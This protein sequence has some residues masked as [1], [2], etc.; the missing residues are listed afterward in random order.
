MNEVETVWVALGIVVLGATLLDVFLTALNYDE[1]GFVSG[2]VAALQWRVLRSVTR[3]M[4]RRA[5]P[6]A[7]RQ[8]T[9]LQII[10]VIAVWLFGV[11]LGFGLIYYGQ[12]TPTSFSVSG[13][14]AG[15]SFFDAMYFSAAQLS[16]VGG[17]SLTAE[18]DVLRFLSIAETLTGVILVSL[19][20]TFLFGVYSVIADLNAL[21]TQF[22]TAERGA[23][24]AVASLAPYFHDGQASGLDDHL[25]GIGGSFASYTSGLRLHHASYYFQSG[26]DRFALPY[27]LRM[28]SGTVGALRWGLPSGHAATVLPALVPLTFQLL[29]FGEYLER[30]VRWRGDSVPEVVDE[31][32]FVR[33]ATDPDHDPRDEWVARFVELDRG[34]AAL[35]GLTPLADPAETYRRYQQWLPFAFRT[36]QFTVAVG[37]DLDYQPIIV[38]D[39]PLSMLAPGDSLT[40]LSIASDLPITPTPPERAPQGTR[41][42]LSRWQGFLDRHASLADPGRSRLRAAGRAA[43]AAV[44]AAAS[45]YLVL[46]V[47]GHGDLRPALFSGFVAMLSTGAAGGTTPRARK[48]TTVLVAVPV[49]LVLLL[50]TFASGS[51]VWTG[52][53]LVALAFACV[54]AG[55]LGARWA[56]LGRVTFMA[57]YYSLILRIEHEQV[58][59]F[60]AAIVLGVAWAFVLTYLVLPDRPRTVLRTGVR[61]FGNRITTSMDALVDAVSWARWDTDVRRR[62]AGDLRQVHRSAAFLAGQL[63][64]DPDAIGM[65]PARAAALRLRVFDAEL[66]VVSLVAA[67]RDATGTAVQLEMRGRLAGR[68][69]FL[70]AHLTAIVEPP[71]GP[72]PELAPW[73]GYHASAGWPAQARAVERVTDELYHAAVALRDAADASFDPSASPS[74]ETS[75][76][77]VD[78]ALL[79]E[80]HDSA[81]GAHDTDG[82]D[83]AG[84]RLL[85]STRRGVQ[86]AV[87]TGAALV[88]GSLVSSTHQYWATLAAYQVLGETDGETFVKGAQRILGTVAGAA[89]GFGIATWTGSD[90]AVVV[91]ALAVA[92]FASTYYRPVSPAVSVFWTTMIFALMYEFLGRLTSLAVEI[93]IVE[94]LV[95]AAIA[96]LVAWLVLPTR[97]RTQLDRDVGTLVKD[98]RVVVAACLERLAGDE[99]ITSAVLGRQLMSVDQHV[100]RVNVTA[101]PLRRSAGASEVGG[102][103]S[104]LTAVWALTQD[105][106]R[107]VRTVSEIVEAGGPT[108]GADWPRLER[109]TEE[110]LAALNDAVAGRLPGV[111]HDDLDVD[112]AGDP[113]VALIP[114]E[115]AALRD[116]ERINQTALLLLSTVSP[117]AVRAGARPQTADA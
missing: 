79:Q 93:R 12:M 116:V 20:L 55:R 66:A 83:G 89:V 33:Q 63:S 11:I 41:G 111:L 28:M 65:D 50:G 61:S 82:T 114:P 117:G 36:Q 85:P 53:L 99:R 70:K 13:T 48:V 31:D 115:R 91:P 40:R 14:G 101:A 109:V 6:V 19:I 95:G 94:T 103:E 10:M 9:G 25:D 4:S 2:R 86:A 74:G 92:V 30:A 42:R 59:L 77:D 110:N 73:T 108:D 113:S 68:L 52:V 56:A 22:F 24:T 35:A 18:T 112:A 57:Y 7:L 17:S 100:R 72:A 81:V 106:R 39:K 5:R 3:R 54:A 34:M 44:A 29:E 43:L 27:A 88:L 15:L 105:A 67:V 87:T 80:L 26:Q 64:G 47:T 49:V 37:R 78:T 60:V 16:T 1:S 75:G 71:V 62:T 90:P 84:P 32:D 21:C 58:L 102:I 107:L 98:I 38:S 97:T 45:L 104:R 46:A 23:G 76:S 51:T 96:L 69:E 8:V